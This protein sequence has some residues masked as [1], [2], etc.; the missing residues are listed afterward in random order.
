[1]TR[2]EPFL[3]SVFV[4]VSSCLMLL[5]CLCLC[6]FFCLESMFAFVCLCV[7]LVRQTLPFT[8]IPMGIANLV[9]VWSQAAALPPY[10]LLHG[11]RHGPCCCVNPTPPIFVNVL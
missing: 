9:Q 6:F 8:M 11:K 10:P 7:P 3:R 1:M 4:L 2:T 5:L